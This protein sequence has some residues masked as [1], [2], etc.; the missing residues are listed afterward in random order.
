MLLTLFR[1]IVFVV[2]NNKEEEA[3]IIYWEKKCNF[4]M[5]RIAHICCMGAAFK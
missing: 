4:Q 5:Q 1:K 2:L 3:D